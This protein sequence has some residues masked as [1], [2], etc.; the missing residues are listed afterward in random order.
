MRNFAILLAAAAISAA[1]ASASA[2]GNIQLAQASPTTTCMMSC[3]AQAASCQT[4][5]VVP[6]TP[7]TASATTTSNA[8]ASTAC[9]LSCSTT[10]LT[11]QTNCA[12]QSPSR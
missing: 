2:E 5:C 1:A 11:C 6:G 8:T 4:G 7:P 3:N 10:Q 12:Q 9:L